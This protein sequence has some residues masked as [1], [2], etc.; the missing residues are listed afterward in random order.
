MLHHHGADLRAGAV[1][2]QPVDGMAAVH[3]GA[4][5]GPR[6]AWA[7]DHRGP[8]HRSPNDASYFLGWMSD[9]MKAAH[10]EDSL[11]YSILYGLA[12]YLLAAAFY[13][14]AAA[15]LKRDIKSY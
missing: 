15:R 3:R 7:G 11:K 14:F 12:F 6:L 2:P 9:A 1:R 10:G 4:D 8:A 13:L 5:A